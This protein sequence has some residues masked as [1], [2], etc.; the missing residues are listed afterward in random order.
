MQL[1]M[2]PRG[3]TVCW[4]AGRTWSTTCAVFRRSCGARPGVCACGHTALESHG[5]CPCCQ[6]G[7]LQTDCVHCGAQVNAL[8]LKLDTLIEDTV[9]YLPALADILGTR[10]TA[11]ESGQL[12]SV[13]VQIG[14]VSDTFRRLATAS[15]E[16]RAWLQRI[17][18]ESGRDPG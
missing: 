12:Q 5:K 1:R 18:R 7:T 16:F 13:R 15:A 6:A 14:A 9:R 10:A 4:V 3:G 2:P 8:G 17:A 11:R